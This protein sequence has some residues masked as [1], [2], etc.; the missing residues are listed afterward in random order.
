MG[1]PAPAFQLT[2][3]ILTALFASNVR[4]SRLIAFVLIFL[5]GLAG[6][7][8]IKLLPEEQKLSRLAGFWLVTGIAPAF[9]VMMSLFASNTAGFTKKSTTAAVIFVGYCVGNLVGPQFFKSNEAPNYTV[10]TSHL[11]LI[12]RRIF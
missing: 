9:P 10:S 11:R 6:I 2:T 8:M 12:R 5:M 7:L 1:L 4:K 3:V